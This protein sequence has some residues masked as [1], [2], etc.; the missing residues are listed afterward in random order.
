MKMRS[1]FF[2]YLLIFGNLTMVSQIKMFCALFLRIWSCNPQ[3][4]SQNREINYSKFVTETKHASFL[5][6]LCYIVMGYW[7][8]LLCISENSLSNALVICSKLGFSV[9]FWQAG[10]RNTACLSSKA[11][12]AQ[13][14]K[15]SP[16]SSSCSSCS[17]SEV[18]LSP[19]LYLFTNQVGFGIICLKIPYHMLPPLDMVLWW[20]NTAAIMLPSSLEDNEYSVLLGDRCTGN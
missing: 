15:F 10:E 13:Q 14:T 20:Q 4:L 19:Y 6:L 16:L 11:L 1:Y 9:V 8:P 18:E 3:Q 17:I 5:V 7:F 12:S 2:Q